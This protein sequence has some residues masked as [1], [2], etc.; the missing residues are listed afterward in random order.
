M[1]ALQSCS[2]SNSFCDTKMSLPSLPFLLEFSKNLPTSHQPTP[3]RFQSNCTC[4]NHFADQTHPQG[5]QIR[6]RHPL[7]LC[8]ENGPNNIIL[9]K[10]YIQISFTYLI[11][12]R[13]VSTICKKC[14]TPGKHFVIYTTSSSIFPLCFCRNFWYTSIM[15]LKV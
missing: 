14:I 1:F 6:I 3:I 15:S 9:V 8:L 4:R 2:D 7:N 11:Y 12:V 13:S 10:T 5:K